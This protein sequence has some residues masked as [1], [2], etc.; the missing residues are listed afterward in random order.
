MLFD[1]IDLTRG[2][3][4]FTSTYPLCLTPAQSPGKS[5]KAIKEQLRVVS[6]KSL[7]CGALHHLVDPAACQAMAALSTAPVTFNYFGRFDQSFTDALPQPL[8]Q[9]T[10]PIHDEQTP[11]SGELNVDGQV[12]DGEPALR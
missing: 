6:R 10:G 8:G 2:V 1:G 4:W 11:L 12:Y 3:G 9:P 5:I 7:G